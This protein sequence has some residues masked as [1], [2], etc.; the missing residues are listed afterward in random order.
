MCLIL[1][2][3]TTLASSYGIFRRII[4]YFALKRPHSNFTSKREFFTLNVC[5]I[6]VTYFKIQFWV[7]F[8][9]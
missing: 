4:R 8:V 9:K 6:A 2:F 5:Y 7:L 1:R 3:N